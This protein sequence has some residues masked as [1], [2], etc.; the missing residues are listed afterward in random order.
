MWFLYMSGLMRSTPH[1]SAGGALILT[2][3]IC[4]IIFFI[5]GTLFGMLC[6]YFVGVRNR[7]VNS[8]NDQQTVS[9]LQPLPVPLYEDVHT[10]PR[11]FRDDKEAI[12]IDENVAYGPI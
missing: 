11:S 10:L 12:K 3:V 5:F 6:S 4:S 7:K 8:V 9:Q 2:A 1:L